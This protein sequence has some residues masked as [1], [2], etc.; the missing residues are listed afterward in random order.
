MST[1][2]TIATH[3]AAVTRLGWIAQDR[4]TLM[5]L[6]KPL[7]IETAQRRHKVLALAPGLTPADQ[8]TLLASG[9][10]SAA[11]ELPGSSLNPFAALAA[12]RR[13]AQTLHEWR[14][15][16][17]I[18]EGETIIELAARA[19]AQSGCSAIYPILPSLELRP[20]LQRVQRSATAAFVATA[21]D[22]RLLAP[23]SQEPWPLPV[24]RL[25]PC[26][27]DLNYLSAEPLPALNAGFV[28]LGI[29]GAKSTPLVEAVASLDGRATSARFRLAADRPNANTA[30][31]AGRVETIEVDQF[32]QI[33][34]RDAVRA[35]HIVVIDGET[36]RHRLA[37]V[38][39]LA[40]GRPVLAIGTAL[41]RETID[42]GV[43]GWLIPDAAPT[44]LAGTLTAIL[45]RP[46]LLPGM[47]RAARQKA[48]RSLDHR[49]AAATLFQVLGLTDLRVQAA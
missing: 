5:L 29:G 14:A 18:V 46:D 7:L 4:E 10:E 43:N 22:V 34:L 19:A 30:A 15:N 31:L 41:Y 12:R 44:T 28:V 32:D 9:I 6:R 38:T 33:S 48:E 23:S 8:L 11:I 45:K 24:H 35:A 1:P 3:R 36:P 16:T 39:A 2:R 37:L 42:A 17:A 20:T 40:M 25:A 49:D 26:A 21:N 13:L 47:A 27:I